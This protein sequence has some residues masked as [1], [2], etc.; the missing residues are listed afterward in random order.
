[1][2]IA[3]DIRPM[4]LPMVG[5]TRYTY[6]LVSRLVHSPHEWFLYCDRE[7]LYPLPDLPNVHLRYGRINSRGLSTLFAQTVFP[8]WA[9]KDRVDVFW[10][11]RHHLPVLLS[12]VASIL[13]I[14]DLV[15]MKY[16]ETMSRMGYWAERLLMPPSIAKAEKIVVVS[17]S[18]N[19]EVSDSFADSVSGVET[20]LPGVSFNPSKN[21]LAFDT[22]FFLFVGTLEPRKNLLTLLQAFALFNE[23]VSGVK[24]ILVGGKG[25]GGESLKARILEYGLEKSVILTDRV[26]ENELADYYANCC[27]LLMPSLYEGFG[28]PLVEAMGHGAPVITTHYGAMKEVAGDAG[29]LVDPHSAQDLCSAMQDLMQPDRRDELSAKARVRAKSFSWDGAAAKMLAAIESLQ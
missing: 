2:R 9:K 11:P 13:T 15:W 14:H 17:E 10:S 4:A 26:S 3:I 22:P 8:F 27:A 24:L 29:I 25:W 23:R 12:S 16:P 18:I 21:E 7:P 5:I 6:E 1:M 28:L 19:E 20:I